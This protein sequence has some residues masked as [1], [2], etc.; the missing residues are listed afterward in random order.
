MSSQLSQKKTV[1]DHGFPP[2]RFYGI[3]PNFPV[4]L[5]V[6]VVTPL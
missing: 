6:T 2:I 4:D 1:T 3:S 5:G